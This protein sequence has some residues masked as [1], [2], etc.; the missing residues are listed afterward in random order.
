[1]DWLREL[2]GIVFW[3]GWFMVAMLAAGSLYAVWWAR[4]NVKALAE[5]NPVDVSDLSEGYHLVWGRTVGPPLQAPLSQRPCVWWSAEVWESVREPGPSGIRHVWRQATQEES[6]RPLLVGDGR[7]IAA[8]WPHSATI[9]SSAWSDWRGDS[10]PPENRTPELQTEGIPGQGIRA[11]AQGTFGPRYRYVEKIIPIDAPLF[12]LADVTR[13]D[14][15]L[16]EPEDDDVATDDEAASADAEF[17]PWR[18]EPS[19]L[20][21]LPTRDAVIA[22]DM[23]RAAW[24][25]SAPKGKPFLISISHPKAVSAEQD[26]GAQGGL[27][28]GAIFTVMALGLLWVRFGG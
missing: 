23:S 20:G 27:T 22:E 14:P 1:M 15:A 21:V 5:Q 12:A 11:D 4:R 19:R 17:E 7:T 18:P 25:V 13:A 9:V 3:W 8:V 26:L 28:M 16:Y 24:T 6:D 10:L 2:P